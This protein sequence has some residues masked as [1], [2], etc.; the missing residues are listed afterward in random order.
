MWLNLF[1]IR[2]CSSLSNASNLPFVETFALSHQQENLLLPQPPP[3]G[4]PL[5]GHN[6]FVNDKIATSAATTTARSLSG[7]ANA[8]SGILAKLGFILQTR[9]TALH[10]VIR[11]PLD[12]HSVYRIILFFKQQNNIPSLCARWFLC[13]SGHNFSMMLLRARVIHIFFFKQYCWKLGFVADWT[14]SASTLLM[15]KLLAINN[16][17]EFLLWYHGEQLKI[18]IL[19][20]KK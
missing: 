8:I 6:H 10:K 9:L 14:K 12:C 5:P 1:G 15:P 19:A 4:L 3:H 13:K 16:S 2:S 17:C 18:S 11:K 7:S 20:L